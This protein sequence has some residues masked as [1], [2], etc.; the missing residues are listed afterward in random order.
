MKREDVREKEGKNGW[1]EKR[2][3]DGEGRRRGGGN[4]GSGMC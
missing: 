1:D 4:S 2:R 3:K